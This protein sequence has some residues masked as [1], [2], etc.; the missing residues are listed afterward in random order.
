MSM[1]NVKL[2]SFC[3]RA[4]LRALLVSD[5]SRV[6]ELPAISLPKDGRQY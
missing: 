1:I 6:L 5:R 2:T 3:A 4:I